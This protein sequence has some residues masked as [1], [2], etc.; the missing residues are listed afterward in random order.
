MSLFLIR[1]AAKCTELNPPAGLMK[2]YIVKGVKKLLTFYEDYD[3]LKKENSEESFD[4]FN[5]HKLYNYTEGQNLDKNNLFYKE[6]YKSLRDLLDSQYQ[7]K[8]K[9]LDDIISVC[10]KT[11]FILV[12]IKLYELSK[13]YD[14][15]LNNYLNPEN[16]ENFSDDVF[17]WLQNIFQSFSRKNNNLS[18]DDYKNLQ[19]AVINKVDL[20]SK[21]SIVKTN[22]IIKQFYGNQEKIIIIHKLDSLPD[23]QYEFLRQLICPSKGGNI[24]EISKNLNDNYINIDE[25]ESKNEDNNDDIKNNNDSLSDLFLLQID[26]LIKLKKIN[27]VL[28]SIKEQIKI[29]PN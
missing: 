8:K 9:E 6:I 10:D 16:K 26:L 28:P 18:E 29:Y 27:E 15:C 5:C 1:Y 25:S 23:L 14:E 22:K 13:K 7:W 3:K 19:K 11:P 21:T 20:L 12:K 4:T 2:E 17:T 24:E